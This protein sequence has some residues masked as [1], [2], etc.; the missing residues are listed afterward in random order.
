MTL[1]NPDI[2]EF[3]FGMGNVLSIYCNSSLAIMCLDTN[4]MCE[5]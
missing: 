2:L 1:Q 4:E 5:P 3:G